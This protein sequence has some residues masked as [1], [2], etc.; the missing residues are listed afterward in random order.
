MEEV[1]C[2]KLIVKKMML[3]NLDY[4]KFTFDDTIV[5]IINSSLNR[6]LL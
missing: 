6:P 2:M 3:G 5:V 1:C 4:I